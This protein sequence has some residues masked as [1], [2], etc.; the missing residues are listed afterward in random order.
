MNEMSPERMS[1]AQDQFWSFAMMS[2]RQVQYDD[3]PADEARYSFSLARNALYHGLKLLGIVP[4]ERV[5]VPAYVCRAAIDPLVA[6]GVNV[7]FYAV[8]RNCEPVIA[9][10]EERISPLTKALLLV[11]YFGFPHKL[12][13]IRNLCKKHGL[14]L[15][16]DCAHVLCGENE[17]V[18]IG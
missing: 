2:F 5:L 9:D 10:L 7:D 15:I 18:P 6:Y 17:G 8:T 1:V 16:E 14:M 13:A 11:H 3:R 4:G 12:S